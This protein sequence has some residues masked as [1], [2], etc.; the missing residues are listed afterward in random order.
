M[1]YTSTEA[2]HGG[3][4]FYLHHRRAADIG[5]QE[6]GRVGADVDYRHPSG[7]RTFSRFLR[8]VV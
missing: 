2:G 1:I 3:A 6:S 7:K 5:Q 8:G 4:A